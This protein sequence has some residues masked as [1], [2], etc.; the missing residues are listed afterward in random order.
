MGA[1]AVICLILPSPA[2]A[3]M[4]TSEWTAVRYLNHERVELGL[5]KLQHNSCV[6]Q[7]A[8]RAARWVVAT[9]E[10]DTALWPLAGK[11]K[12]RCGLAEFR[13][14]SVRGQWAAQAVDKLLASVSHRS[15]CTVPTD[16]VIG[17]AKVSAGSGKWIWYVIV[18]RPTAS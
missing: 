11:V 12:E 15:D 9:Y 14:S 18:G 8:V 5:G 6:E 13:H 17:V 10:G 3:Y 2:Q 7:V 4:N 16:T 1:V